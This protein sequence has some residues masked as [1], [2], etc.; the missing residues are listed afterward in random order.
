MLWTND[1]FR[2][3]LQWILNKGDFSELHFL[4]HCKSPQSGL[5][6]AGH[7]HGTSEPGL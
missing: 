5:S 7:G 3:K 2:N 4:K 6:M 1:E